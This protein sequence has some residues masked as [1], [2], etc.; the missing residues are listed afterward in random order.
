[1]ASSMNIMGTYSGITMD[2]IEQLISAESSKV[3]Q[4]TNEQKAVEAEKN[5]WKDVQTRLSNLT[6]KLTTLGKD[7]T[8]DS[9]KV[10]TS[11]QGKVSV[12]ATKEVLAGT[13]QLEVERLATRAQLT[14]DKIDLED[15]ELA[16]PF[17]LEG[18]LTFSSFRE[19]AESNK[20]D[21]KTFNV[22]IKPNQSLKDILTAINEKGK[23]AGVSAVLID[24]HVVLQS[25]T[26]GARRLSVSGEGEMAGKL[27]IDKTSE[28]AKDASFKV[29][30]IAIEHSS[31]TVSDAIEGMTI[32]LQGVTE[33]PVEVKVAEDQDKTI[34]AVKALVDQY[35]STLSFISDQLDVGD[36]TQE[37][38][39]TGALAGDS[40]L[41]RLE[42][43][44]RNLFTQPVENGNKDLNA[45]KS[46]GLDVDR[47]G[48]ATLDEV[49]LKEAL[50]KDPQAVKDL[51]TFT[52]VTTDGTTNEEKSEK[53][54][55]S[56]RMKTLL[57]SY[58]NS[59]DG[60]I[61]TRNDTYDKLI[62]D[63]NS[64]I[65]TFNERLE[66]KR[67]R[68]IETFTALDIAMMEAESQMSWLTSQIGG[69]TTNN[70]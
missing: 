58:T 32:N 23:D 24:N 68:Y 37:D 53:I 46:I 54:G 42:S 60:I 64:R 30:G 19:D 39:K 51:F 70:K 15:K 25:E 6:D 66:A 69:L 21:E 29:N 34:S 44:L 31:N 22:E 5:A 8:F 12:S 16:D 9:R 17:G 3:V 10:T 36:P 56:D 35:N 28:I 57:E 26:T 27:G 65:D 63:L 20:V 1:M 67:Q 43:Q 38:N 41:M 14:G 7:E 33:S 47:N 2:T 49:K 62:K 52:K 59:K 11:V 4:Y 50:A 48:T 13:Y 45:A 18:T 61:K 40:S 55:I